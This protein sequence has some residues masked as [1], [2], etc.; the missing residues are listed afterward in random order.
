MPTCRWM[1]DLLDAPL[2]P[3]P[4]ESLSS[5]E[6]ELTSNLFCDVNGELI[7]FSEAHVKVRGNAPWC[8]VRS[9]LFVFFAKF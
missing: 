1:L 5:S 7:T 3:R 2:M 4:W 6:L 9:Q 8:L